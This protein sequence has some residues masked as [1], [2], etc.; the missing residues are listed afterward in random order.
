VEETKKTNLEGKGESINAGVSSEAVATALALED[1]LPS[2]AKKGLSGWWLVEIW[3][4]N[5][6][7]FKA[8]CTH[9]LIFLSVIFLFILIHY[10][11]DHTNLPAERKEILATV[12]FWSIYAAL[13]IFTIGFII[14]LIVLT[15]SRLLELKK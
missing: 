15:V 14:E 13:L 12:D 11:L 3:V 6:G 4:E 5:R 9:A 10:V 8:L 1:N 2:Q 7:T